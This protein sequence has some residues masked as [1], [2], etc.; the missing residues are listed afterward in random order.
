M[1]GTSGAAGTSLEASCFLGYGSMLC[2]IIYPLLGGCGITF[3]VICCDYSCRSH[4]FGSKG[5]VYGHGEA[6]V[7][8]VIGHFNFHSCSNI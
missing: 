7:R 2:M 6:V 1:F 8:E 4:C 3:R 5:K